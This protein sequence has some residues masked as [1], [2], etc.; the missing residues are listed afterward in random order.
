MDLVRFNTLGIYYHHIFNVLDRFV[1]E[2]SLKFLVFGNFS[3]C[4]HKIFINDIL[5]LSPEQKCFN[6][7][8]KEIL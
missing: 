4:L 7:Y 6:K 2:L 8:W 1:V 5:P 3:H